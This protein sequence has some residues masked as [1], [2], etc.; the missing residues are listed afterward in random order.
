MKKP[1]FS[2]SMFLQRHRG[3]VRVSRGDLPHTFSPN[4]F[5]RHNQ[6]LWRQIRFLDPTNSKFSQMYTE[7]FW[8]LTNGCQPRMQNFADGVVESGNADVVW[9]SDSRL[10]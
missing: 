9:N 8:K 1:S 3:Y 7:F 2:Q 5:R 6:L 4:Q 10:L